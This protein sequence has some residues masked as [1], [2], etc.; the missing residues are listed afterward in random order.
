MILQLLSLGMRNLFHPWF[1]SVMIYTAN[2]IMEAAGVC[3]KA[4]KSR[5]LKFGIDYSHMDLVAWRLEPSSYGFL[6]RILLIYVCIVEVLN[7]GKIQRDSVLARKNFLD[8]SNLMEASNIFI[9]CI[10]I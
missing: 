6:N 9:T 3:F 8:F 7:S 1:L 10:T 2:Q 5:W 4:L